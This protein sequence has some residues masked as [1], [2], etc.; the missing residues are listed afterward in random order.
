MG[1]VFY[2]W[3]YFGF[4]G[5]DLTRFKSLSAVSRIWSLVLAVGF[6]VLGLLA[7]FKED[8]RKTLVGI[9]IA[10]IL[11]LDSPKRKSA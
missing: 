11:V 9:G 8:T 3:R 2:L 1:V 4:V 10:T 7:S 5:Y 6:P